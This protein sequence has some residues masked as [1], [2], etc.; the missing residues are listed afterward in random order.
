MLY[1]KQ[2]FNLYDNKMQLTKSEL[3]NS[4][5]LKDKKMDK[6]LIYN[7]NYGNQYNIKIICELV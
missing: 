3:Y 2:F 7:F 4:L 6:K 5:V 1:I